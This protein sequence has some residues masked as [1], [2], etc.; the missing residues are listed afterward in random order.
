MTQSNS[1]DVYVVMQSGSVT[2]CD[3]SISETVI[4]QARSGGRKVK[5]FRN[6]EKY[7]EYLDEMDREYK[8]MKEA[9]IY[10]GALHE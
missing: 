9:M 5:V 6:R 7:L 2:I 3:E 10:E 8:N 4:R 1:D